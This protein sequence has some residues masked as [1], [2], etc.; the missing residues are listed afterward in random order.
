MLRYKKSQA[1]FE[2]FKYVLALL[3]AL[4]VLGIGYNSINSVRDKAC[5]TE[6]AQ[7]EIEARNLGVEL[8]YG[9][10]EKRD[11]K[12]PCSIDK[13]YLF[14]LDAGVDASQ[15]TGIPLIRDSIRSGSSNIFLVKDGQ[16][17]RSF[18][19]GKL[20]IS[21]PHYLC[22]APKNDMISVFLEGS[23]SYVTV[24]V[25]SSQPLCN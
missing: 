2:I 4:L 15:F 7:F 23:G 19:A 10:R 1:I 24:T 25:P 5:K 22:L 14:D 11:F 6:L 18:Y 20:R 17:K 13:L 8:R 12:A 16:V 9:S 21:A 3:L